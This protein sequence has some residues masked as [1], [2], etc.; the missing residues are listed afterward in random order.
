MGRER[1][2]LRWLCLCFMFPLWWSARIQIFICLCTGLLIIRIL[3]TSFST[4]ALTNFRLNQQNTAFTMQQIIFTLSH[5]IH[6]IK[7]NKYIQHPVHAMCAARQRI[8]T[9]TNSGMLKQT[10]IILYHIRQV[11]KDSLTSSGYMISDRVRRRS[12]PC[13]GCSEACP[14]LHSFTNTRRKH[15]R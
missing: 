7:W 14:L 2:L 11:I 5:T 12:L 9:K 1:R 15:C 4:L 13:D 10:V 3:L 6:E 8:D